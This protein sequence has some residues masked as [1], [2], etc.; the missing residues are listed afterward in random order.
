MWPKILFILFVIFMGMSLFCYF[1]WIKCSSTPPHRLFSFFPNPSINVT[2]CSLTPANHPSTHSN[3][4]LTTLR[5]PLTLIHPF[6]FPL[7]RILEHTITIFTHYSRLLMPRC[8]ALALPRHYLTPPHCP[9]T[10][11]CL[12]LLSLECHLLPLWCHLTPFVVL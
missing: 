7:H 12:P 8:R 1:D 2:R 10:P 9:S 11:P 4:H 3:R 5:H 6:L